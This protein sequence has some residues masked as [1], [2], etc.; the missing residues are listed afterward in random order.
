MVMMLKEFC[1]LI[2]DGGGDVNESSII[3]YQKDFLLDCVISENLHNSI[4]EKFSHVF[5]S[6]IGAVRV[7]VGYIVFVDAFSLIR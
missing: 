1:S 2:D 4:R 5:L 7:R 3:I 6:Y